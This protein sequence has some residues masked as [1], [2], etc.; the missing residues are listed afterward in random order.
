[1]LHVDR[2]FSVRGAGT[3][4]TGTLWSG[5]IARG[6]RLQ[7]L[8]SGEEVRVRGVQVHDEAVERARA[9]QR[10]ALNLSGVARARVRRGDVLAASDTEIRETFRLDARLRLVGETAPG[11]RVQV[12]HGTRESPARL[13]RLDGEHWQVRLEQPLIAAAGDHVVVRRISVPDTLGGGVILDAT[14]RRHGPSPEILARLRR[15]EAAQPAGP[16]RRVDLA[17]AREPAAP[18]AP[19]PAEHAAPASLS[20]A[21]LALEE[22]LRAAGP[23]PPSEAELGADATY[24]PELRAAGRAIRVGRSMYAHV[25]AVAEVRVVV[26]RL[27]AAEGA[28]TL[29]RLRDELAISRRYAQALLEHL[30]SARVTR[31][32]PDDSRVLRG[33]SGAA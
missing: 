29:A 31:R 7:L 12:H 23:R 5:S 11:E 10:V 30:D 22:R 25:D 3:V 20:A 9:G 15:G 26:E 19:A 21:A 1:V 28:V 6:E 32:R 13:V 2:V 8:P 24:L 16:A 18:A 33:S 4:V 14:P 17:R 27:I